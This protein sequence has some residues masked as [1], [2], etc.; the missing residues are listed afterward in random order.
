MLN[1]DN[2]M[3]IIVIYEIIQSNFLRYVIPLAEK[4]SLAEPSLKVVLLADSFVKNDKILQTPFVRDG[5][6]YFWYVKEFKKRIRKEDIAILAYINYS[7]R[8]PDLYWTFFFKRMNV[9]TF[10]IQHGMYLKYL[11]RDVSSISSRLHRNLSYLRYLF[12]LSGNVKLSNRLNTFF[13][14]LNKDFINSDELR[15]RFSSSN[16][17]EF[18]SDTLMIWGNYWKEWFKRV[19]YYTEKCEYIVIGNK[20]YYLAKESLSKPLEDKTCYVCQTFVEDGRM[21]VKNFR[22]FVDTLVEIYKNE[23]D[24]QLLIKFHPRSEKKIYQ[25]L[26]DLPNVEEVTYFPKCKKYIGHYSTILSLA[27]S[28]ETYVALWSFEGH[29]IPS[30]FIEMA[31]LHTS[32]EIELEQFIKQKKLSKKDN[33]ISVDYYFSRVEK[34]PDLTIIKRL[35]NN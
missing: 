18:K 31:D 14:L 27:F 23:I 32:S 10:Q 16:F 3:K 15:K 11:K 25:T 30:L 34:D 26:L 29:D 5:E 12:M 7:Y 22:K 21:S 20:D 1:M 2:K 33:N 24:E 6:I 8:I 17:E 9:P 28:E 19:H 4:I 35:F 13:F